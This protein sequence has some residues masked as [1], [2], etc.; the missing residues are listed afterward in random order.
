MFCKNCGKQV[1]DDAVF[2]TNCG[3]KIVM[4]SEAQSTPSMQVISNTQSFQNV[5]PP[6]S[7]QPPN[8]NPVNRKK[9]SWIIPTALV[10]CV[11]VIIGVFLF[12]IYWYQDADEETVFIND[13]NTLKSESSEDNFSSDTEHQ[14]IM[15]DYEEAD[16]GNEEQ[17]NLEDTE[18]MQE[19][20]VHTYELI[21][22]DVTWAEAYRLCIE[23]GGYLVRINSDMEMQIILQQIGTEDKNNIKFWIGGARDDSSYTYRWIYENT[24][25]EGED[26]NNNKKYASYWLDGEPSYMDDS[27]GTTEM[28]M[29]M[30]YVKSQER[31]VWN[32]TV[33]NILEVLPEYSGTIGYICE[34]EY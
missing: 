2:C 3:M 7:I 17:K 16:E 22:A 29:N 9:F 18:E 19:N 8:Y 32:D 6:V 34:Y 30:F 27:I 15:F 23:R 1:K 26:L 25:Y 11:L 21:V 13:F 12:V 10:A 33:N 24:D 4:P 14:Y 20:E 31:W 28:Y 5:Q